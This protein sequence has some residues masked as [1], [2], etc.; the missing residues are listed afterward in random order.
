MVLLVFHLHI[1]VTKFWFLFKFPYTPKVR[2]WSLDCVR[3]PPSCLPCALCVL[4]EVP[5]P[6]SLWLGSV[7]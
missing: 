7:E 3:F 5:A 2:L 4:G 1:F 6:C